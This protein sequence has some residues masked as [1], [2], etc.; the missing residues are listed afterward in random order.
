MTKTLLST[1]AL[2]ISA[3]FWAQEIKIDTLYI[4]D[5]QLNKAKSF[6]KIITLKTNDLQKNGS[7]LSEVLRFQSPVFIKENGRGMASSP[8]FRGTTASHTAFIWN[9]VN[10]NSTFLGQGDINNIGLLDSDRLDIKSGGGSVLY[11]S[12][13]IGGSIHFNDELTFNKGLKGTLYSEYGSFETYSN[14]LKSSYSNDHFS[15]KVAANHFISQNDF[16][17]KDKKY[18]NRN[19][20]YYNTSFSLGT[21][22]RFNN[23]NTVSW[24]SQTLNN[25]QHYPIFEESGTKTKYLTQNFRS[26]LTW[27]HNKTGFNNSL[28]LV[29][30]E[31]NFQ[32]FGNLNKEKTSGGT[33]KNYILKNDSDYSLNSKF[34]INTIFDFQQNQ[35]EGYSSGIGR[36]KRNI[37]SA[38]GMLRYFSDDW[39]FEA[40]IKKDFIEDIQ[41]PLLF[42]FSSKW[43]HL[44]WYNVSLNLS[45]NFR[46]GSFNDLYWSPGGNIHLKPETS[47]QIE[48]NHDF[49]F[50]NLKLTL[51]PYYMN[52]QDMIRWLPTS[53]SNYWSVYNTNK[54]VSYGVESIINYQ[55][56][57]NNSSY[58]KTS[59]GY[60]YIRSIN[61]ET[62]KQLML[63]P[64]HK[65]FGN[66][67]YNYKFL[68]LYI[69][70]MFTGLTYTGTDE[71]KN[72]ALQPYFLL[73]SGISATI[74]KF[75]FGLRVN[76]IT[77]TIYRTSDANFWMPKRNFSVYTS[78]NF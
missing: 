69:Q 13:A 34:S 63:V 41:S 39:N 42:S 48:M 65:A 2:Y 31:D 38:A 33:G 74:S 54:V 60:S 62:K 9:G 17:V 18:I 71:K 27:D 75:N 67:D 72:T 40:G 52:I 58:L 7:N 61:M 64:Y 46:Y 35:G 19:A 11:G 76:N 28:K 43:K 14:I 8:S 22:Y 50:K 23:F 51:S 30:T 44:K 53:S 45:K 4:F 73:N 21:S 5:K 78:I 6:H 15:F 55:H 24:Q 10:I 20:R 29:Y 26:L 70:G 37:L 16:E 1:A 68:T 49:K 77:N 57:F 66:L 12:G 3:L 56:N 59:V 47:M 32:Y 25:S 36:I